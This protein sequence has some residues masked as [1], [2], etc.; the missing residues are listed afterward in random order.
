MNCPADD[1]QPDLDE[2]LRGEAVDADDVYEK[3]QKQRVYA[4]N[5]GAEYIT[6]F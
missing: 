6:P 3:L 5:R 2:D 4:E 1:E